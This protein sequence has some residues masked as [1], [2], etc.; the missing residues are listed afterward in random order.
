MIFRMGATPTRKFGFAKKVLFKNYPKASQMTMNAYKQA[1]RAI[2]ED[3]TSEDF[4]R[5]NWE[6]TV[7]E[8]VSRLEEVRDNAQESY[9][10]MPEHLAETSSSGQLLQERIDLAEQNIND[11]EGI[12]GDE[13]TPGERFDEVMSMIEEA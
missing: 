10:N 2:S 4:F 13:M 9:D 8:I 1:I 12:D 6:D 3:F 7:V 5:S 11:L